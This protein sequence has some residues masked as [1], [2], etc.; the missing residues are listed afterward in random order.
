MYKPQCSKSN[1]GAIKEETAKNILDVTGSGWGRN[2]G[3]PIFLKNLRHQ[4]L[5]NLKSE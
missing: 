5:S 2:W 4:I 3:T 1:L